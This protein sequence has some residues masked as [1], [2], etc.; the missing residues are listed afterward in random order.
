MQVSETCDDDNPYQ[1]ITGTAVNGANESDQ[2]ALIPMV[3]QLDDSGMKPDDFQADRGYGSGENIVECAKRGV[4]L[5]AP[6]QDPD[7]PKATEH[8]KAPVEQ[9]QASSA[10]KQVEQQPAEPVMMGLEEFTFNSTFDGVE[11][12]PSGHAP[13]RQDLSGGVVF[14]VFAA[15]VCSL[16]PMASRCPTRPLANGD[17][18]FRRAPATIATECRQAEQQTA[19]FKESYR[20]RS[21]IESTNQELKGRHGLGDLRIRG[22]PR[23]ELAVTLK[24][25]ALN[26][27]R[28]MQFFVHHVLKMAQNAP[29]PC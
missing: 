27:K 21:G 19:A 23:V 13:T 26:L 14:A 20:K 5:E 4:K 15:T 3:D 29:A 16:C 22:K 18:Q 7:A 25:L 8:F 9:T 24:S 2:N 10:D 6:V 28:A 12:C 1:V 11:S 17:R